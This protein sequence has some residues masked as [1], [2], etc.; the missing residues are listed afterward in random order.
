LFFASLLVAIIPPLVKGGEWYAWIYKGLELLVISCPCSLIVSTP[1]CIVAGITAAAR[2]GVLIKGGI[3]LEKAANLR[4]FAMDKTGT[5]TTGQPVV[6]EI[7]PLEDF[8]SEDILSLAA[9]LEVNSDH[10]L[11]RAIL[12]RAKTDGI[13]FKSA[14][15]FKVFKGKGAEGILMDKMYWIGSHRFLHEKIG[16]HEA[17]DLHDRI[18]RLENAG[19]SIVAIGQDLK[20]CGFIS[21]ADAVRLESKSAIKALKK[22][23]VQSVVKLTG[24]NS[25][26]AKVIADSVEIDEYYAELLP[27]DKV[28]QVQNLVKKYKLVAMVG[29]GINDAPAMAASSLGIAMGSAGSDAAI[30]TADIALMSDDLGKLAWLVNHSRRTITIIKENVIFSL[31]VKAVFVGLTFANKSSLWLAIIADMGATFLVVTNALRLVGFS[32]DNKRSSKNTESLQ[33]QQVMLSGTVS[34]T[35]IEIPSDLE[36]GSLIPNKNSPPATKTCKSGCKH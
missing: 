24:D 34:S 5:L 23:G 7:I 29:D 15:Q 13:L 14:D 18:T 26:A 11:A 36:N 1:V 10:P 4:A 33:Q 12:S 27:E 2:K 9:S 32:K 31:A 21:I 3:H 25:G 8:K 16:D 17:K 20:I 35:P 30:E 6:Y 19:H 22:S 28:K